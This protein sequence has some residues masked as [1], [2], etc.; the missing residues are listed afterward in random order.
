MKRIEKVEH[1]WC[2]Q[3][4]RWVYI[5]RYEGGEI[6]LNFVQGNDYEYFKEGWCAV[7]KGLSE[8][9]EQMRLLIPIQRQSESDISFINT[10]IWAYHSAIASYEQYS[11]D[12]TN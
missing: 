3:D 1:I 9:Y 6:G 5:E 8:F 12:F 11:Q 7:D 10:V 2:D 4:D